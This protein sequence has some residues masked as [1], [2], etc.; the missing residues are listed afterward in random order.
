MGSSRGSHGPRQRLRL[1]GGT[2]LSFVTAGDASKPAVLLLHGFP[3]SSA[4]F[5]EVIPD[6]AR[7]AYVIAPDLP[8]FGESGVLPTVS[9]PALGRAISELLERL[10]VGPRYIY[11]HDFG[12]P[13]G[14]HVAMRAPEE[15]LGLIVQNA[16]AHRTGLGPGWEATIAYWS[17]PT[18]E[19]EAAATAHLTLEGTR[20][21]Y[22]A[23]VPPDVTASIPA[24]RWEEDWR[25]MCL[26]GR[27]ELQRTLIADYGRYV[28]R[29]GVIA[30][31]LRDWQPPALLLWG[32]HDSFFDLS[33]TVSWMQVLPRME[34]HI[35]DAGHLL[36]ET[37]SVEATPLMLDFIRHTQVQ[38]GQGA[39]PD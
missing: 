12:A 21:Q 27:M 36:L 29:F 26:P 17:S 19:N 23:A 39:A 13:V 4:M 16:N 34:A 7:I 2:E 15:V 9:F 10:G 6:L 8:G 38:A 25:I 32:R 5:R 30:E 35:L 37:H 1:S 33:E 11:L 22:L 14:L 28:D 18:P 20:D 31:Y 3:N 24:E